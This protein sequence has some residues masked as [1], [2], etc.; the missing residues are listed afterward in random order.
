MSDLFVNHDLGLGPVLDFNFCST[1]G[2]DRGFVLDPIA[3][4]IPIPTPLL[5]LLSVPLPF[6]MTIAMANMHYVAYAPYGFIRVEYCSYFA[7]NSRLRVVYSE[8]SLRD[9]C[10]V[11]LKDT[12]R[13]RNSDVR[14]RCDLKED[15]A[16]RVE[17]GM[18]RWFGHLERVNESRPTKQ[19]YRANVCDGKVVSATASPLLNV[20]FPFGVP[21]RTIL[22][23]L[24]QHLQQKLGGARPRRY[25][26]YA[27]FNITAA[28]SA[29]TYR[30]RAERD[31]AHR[32]TRPRRNNSKL[33]QKCNLR[34]YWMASRGQIGYTQPAPTGPADSSDDGASPLYSFV[35]PTLEKRS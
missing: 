8:R 13:S 22:G 34:V 2:S 15:V 14:E 27:V 26:D 24:H 19:I 12:R 33:L 29:T 16:T 23:Y 10:Q 32:R 31:A 9:M 35:G 28:N 4:L 1:I 5:L 11:F 7:A 17:R 30:A 6:S 25:V 3:F 18:L 20:G 21:P